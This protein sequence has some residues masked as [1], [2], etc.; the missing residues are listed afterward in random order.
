MYQAILFPFFLI[1]D[2]EFLIKY[3][4]RVWL[5]HLSCSTLTTLEAQGFYKTQRQSLVSIRILHFVL[6]DTA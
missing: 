2:Y 3:F 5:R 4:S 6:M 1:D